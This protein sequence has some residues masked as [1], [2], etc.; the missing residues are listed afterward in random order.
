M[1][2]VL[3]EAALYIQLY[4]L[5]MIAELC[6]NIKIITANTK[7]TVRHYDDSLS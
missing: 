2:I 4:S 7:C 3:T 6:K 1:H 5:R